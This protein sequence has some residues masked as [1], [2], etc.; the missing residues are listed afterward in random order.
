MICQRDDFLG[1][2][3]LLRHENMSVDC[4]EK[5]VDIRWIAYKRIIELAIL[6]SLPSAVV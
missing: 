6:L 3:P 5:A 4:R 2:V 1:V